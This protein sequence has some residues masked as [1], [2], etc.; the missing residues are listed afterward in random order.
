MIYDKILF[1]PWDEDIIFEA[2]NSCFQKTKK[3]KTILLSKKT[4]YC[5][6]NSVDWIQLN[7]KSAAAL[8]HLYYTYEFSDKFIA[9]STDSNFGTIWNYVKTGIL[10]PEE[11]LSAVL[12]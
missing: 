12:V 8:R 10:T 9:L 3:K 7:E 4:V 6:S 5:G 1:F 11:A 2:F